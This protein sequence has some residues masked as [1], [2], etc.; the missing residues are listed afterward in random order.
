MWQS[1]RNN[2]H[3]FH[4]QNPQLCSHVTCVEDLYRIEVLF[5]GKKMVERCARGAGFDGGSAYVVHSSILIQ[6]K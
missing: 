6:L 2:T 1:L 4:I 5:G 3:P